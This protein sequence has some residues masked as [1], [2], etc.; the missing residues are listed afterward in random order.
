MKILIG[1]D[2]KQITSILSQYTEKE[3]YEVETAEDGQEVLDKFDDE[4]INLILLDV[5][6]PKIDGTNYHDHRS[7]RRL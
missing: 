3:G 1:D 5:M 4:S 6:M 2:N 7:I